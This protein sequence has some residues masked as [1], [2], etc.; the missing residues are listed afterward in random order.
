MN[1]FLR[2]KFFSKKSRKVE[3]RIKL[4]QYH[5]ANFFDRLFNDTSIIS[6]LDYH[7][8]HLK[9]LRKKPKKFSDGELINLKKSLEIRNKILF[10][11]IRKA[12]LKNINKK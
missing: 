7:I 5:R 9:M 11:T 10:R 2:F 4:L 8:D 12:K 6:L 3:G 1:K